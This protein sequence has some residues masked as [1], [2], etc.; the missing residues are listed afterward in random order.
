MEDEIPS[1]CRAICQLDD[2]DKFCVGCYRTSEE[3]AHWE[4]FDNEK[5]KAVVAEAQMRRLRDGG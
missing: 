1:P 4:A 5:K 2:E 3:I